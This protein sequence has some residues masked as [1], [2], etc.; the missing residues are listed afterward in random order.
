MFFD[1]SWYTRAL[2]EPT[3]G[4]CTESQYK[5]FMGN[6][7]DWEKKLMKQ[8]LEL[9]KFYLSV[10][11]ETQLVR[12]H[13][14]T[15]RPSEV[16]EDFLTDFKVRRQWERFSMYKE[17]MFARTSSKSSPWVIVNSNL[18]RQSILTCMLYLV[19]LN[20]KAFVPLTG[21]MMA[22]DY[23]IELQGVKFKALS[24]KQYAVL[25]GLQMRSEQ[26]M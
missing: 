20:R 18:K 14:K 6:V 15:E 17:Q 26:G 16:L 9:V 3:L 21:E 4:Y 11:I 23:E 13:K 7:L 5:Y 8:G 19:N 22:T 2:T 10:D 25:S 1:R 24:A 12:F